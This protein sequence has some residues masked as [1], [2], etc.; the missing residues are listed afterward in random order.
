MVLFLRLLDAMARNWLRSIHN[1]V[2]I[3]SCHNLQKLRNLL[4]FLDISSGLQY[5]NSTFQKAERRILRDSIICCSAARVLRLPG[6][7][8]S[9]AGAGGNACIFDFKP[10]QCAALVPAFDDPRDGLK[11]SLEGYGYGQ[12]HCAV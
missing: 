3:I 5:S 10:M 7:R 2:N 9:G 4:I 6:L 12:H 1:T 11:F 8:N